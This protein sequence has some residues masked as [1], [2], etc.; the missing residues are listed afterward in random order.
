MSYRPV[1]L[2]WK[3]V[4]SHLEIKDLERA[5]RQEIFS[6]GILLA[7][8]VAL[9]FLGAILIVR[10]ISRESETARLKTQFVH[11]ISNELKTPLTLIRLYG[12]TLQRKKHLTNEER[13]E[14]YQIITKESERLSH[15]I[16]N[17]L[18]FSRIE[19]DRKEFSFRKGNLAKVVRDTLESFHYHLEKKG[20]TLQTEIATDLPELNFDGEAIPSVL[21]NLLSR[22]GEKLYPSCCDP[23]IMIT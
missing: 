5:A 9:M 13:K 12:E 3:L 14:S 20:F 2:P 8:I 19:T 21:V 10:D 7:V 23:F 17:V 18:D 11:N 6:Y 15:L 4:V 1:P 22:G 16:D